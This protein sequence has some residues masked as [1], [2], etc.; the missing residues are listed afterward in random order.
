LVVH[1]VRR[2]FVIF[3]TNGDGTLTKADFHIMFH[4][5]FSTRQNATR[6]IMKSEGGRATL[7]EYAKAE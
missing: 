7:L 5:A 6:M 4:A 3:D 1:Q 2:G